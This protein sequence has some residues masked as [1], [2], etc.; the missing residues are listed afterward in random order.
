MCRLGIYRI[1]KA[2]KGPIEFISRCSLI[3][4]LAF[5][6]EFNADVDLFIACQLAVKEYL[7][8]SERILIHGI[9]VGRYRIAGFILHD[10]SHILRFVS[11]GAELRGGNSAGGRISSC[12]DADGELIFRSGFKALKGGALL[13]CAIAALIFRTLNSRKGY[14]IVGR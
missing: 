11:L 3:E 14:G 2:V 4:F 13:P 5:L 12:L 7:L 8:F 9:M 1:F 10:N 6:G